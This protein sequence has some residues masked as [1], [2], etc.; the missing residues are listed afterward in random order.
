MSALLLAAKAAQR[1]VATLRCDADVSKGVYPLEARLTTFI[2]GYDSTPTAR[3]VSISCKAVDFF[4]SLH[5]GLRAVLSYT[6]QT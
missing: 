1:T 6:P 2:G 3:N 5:S 4:D